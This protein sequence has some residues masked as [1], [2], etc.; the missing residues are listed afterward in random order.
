MHL[1]VQDVELYAKT[2]VQEAAGY[3]QASH[4]SSTACPCARCGKMQTVPLC[5]NLCLASRAEVRSHTLQRAPQA[6]LG[7]T[8]AQGACRQCGVRRAG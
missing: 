8:C 6:A 1:H 2:F 7:V 5:S 3:I 4:A